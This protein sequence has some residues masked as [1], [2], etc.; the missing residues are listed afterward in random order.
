M[1]Y[2]IETI[3]TAGGQHIKLRK[4]SHVDSVSFNNVIIYPLSVPGYGNIMEAAASDDVVKI[5]SA[6][7]LNVF[8]CK[9]RTN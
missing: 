5:I 8:M 7:Q 2:H 4:L 1:T 3:V 9:L 6:F